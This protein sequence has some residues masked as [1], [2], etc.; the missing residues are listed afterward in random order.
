MFR[1]KEARELNGISQKML[2]IRLGIAQTTVSGWENDNKRPSVD[3]IIKI[4][5]I[6]NVT[7]DYLLG[8]SSTPSAPNS[9]ESPMMKVSYHEKALVCAYREHK[10]MQLAVCQLLG[11]RHPSTEISQASRA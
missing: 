6:L 3:T 4:S 5:E 1:I 9:E 10:E 8:L 2:A 7:T 11:V